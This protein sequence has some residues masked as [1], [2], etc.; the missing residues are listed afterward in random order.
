[1]HAD[2][3]GTNAGYGSLQQLDKRDSRR[4]SQSDMSCIDQPTK[5]SH[6][7][8][9]SISSASISSQEERRTQGPSASTVS[10]MNRSQGGAP[11]AI[12]AST[13]KRASRVLSSEFN[14]SQNDREMLPRNHSRSSL[15]SLLHPRPRSMPMAGEALP[16]TY[17]HPERSQTVSFAE[18]P[19]SKRTNGDDLDARRWS[20]SEILP[21]E[22]MRPASPSSRGKKSRPKSLTSLLLL[23]DQSSSGAQPR[24]PHQ[25]KLTRWANRGGI[26]ANEMMLEL[27]TTG[28]FVPSNAR[29]LRSELVYRTVIQCADEIRCRGLDHPNIFNNP[30]PKKVISAMIALLSDQDGCD[31][32]LQCLRIDTVAGLVLNVLSQMSNPV[33][34]YAVMEHYF[35]QGGLITR[36]PILSPHSSTAAR[37]QG[38]P[39]ALK[40]NTIIERSSSSESVTLG[41]FLPVIPMLPA[42]GSA[43]ACIAWAREYFNLPAFLD[44]LPAMN[45]VIL[46]EVLH[47]CQEILQYQTVNRATVP[48]LVQLFAPALFSTVFDQKILESMSG[49]S[50]RCS[51]HGDNVSPEEG[52]RVENHLF[53]VILVRFLRLNA[54]VTPTTTMSDLMNSGEFSTSRNSVQSDMNW[55]DEEMVDESAEVAGEGI[56][57]YSSRTSFRK[58]QERLQQEQEAYYRRLERSYQEMEIQQ[59]P[60][61]HFGVYG[62]SQKL[63]DECGQENDATSSVS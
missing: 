57:R 59:R 24:L 19:G 25:S 46:L 43:N 11:A 9:T 40:R 8:S 17:N 49:G 18:V 10:R 47:L 20:R 12:V 16:D 30:S 63:Q 3:N 39:K 51:I 36:S 60:P 38:S 33:I 53:M 7:P 26:G 37:Q 13:D 55:A 48:R 4:S 5:G 22:A 56:R 31:Y 58:S 35:K 23:N 45:R 61:Q 52:S 62:S 1:M 14:S 32:P 15:T 50:A 44:V 42:R 54:G 21:A 27:E 41:T 34:P 28:V 6:S 29:R 2:R